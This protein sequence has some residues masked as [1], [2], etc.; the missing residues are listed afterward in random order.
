[1]TYQP[2]HNRNDSASNSYYSERRHSE[3]D[4][5][6]KRISAVSTL[7][8]LPTKEDKRQTLLAPTAGRDDRYSDIYDAY[9]RQSM[10]QGSSEPPR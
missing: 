8:P 10:I 3:L 2:T 1:M 7:A 5:D 6:S 4:H 9:Y